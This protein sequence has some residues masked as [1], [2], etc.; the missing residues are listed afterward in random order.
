MIDINKLLDEAQYGSRGNF[1]ESRITPEAAEFWEAVKK[2]IT[3]DN[4]KMKS[5]TLTRILKDNFDIRISDTA[6]TNYL[7]KLYNAK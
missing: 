7:E 5:Y 6:M 2:R 3:E 4:V 1:V